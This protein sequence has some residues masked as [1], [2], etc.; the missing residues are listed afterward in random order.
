MQS[1][2]ILCELP[3]VAIRRFGVS[4]TRSCLHGHVEFSL[5]R[6]R[7]TRAGIGICAVADMR[8]PKTPVN[9][10]SLMRHSGF[11]PQNVP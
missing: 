9:F 3:A 8:I 2:V 7:L 1:S 10:E 11:A 4:R 5:P 6:C